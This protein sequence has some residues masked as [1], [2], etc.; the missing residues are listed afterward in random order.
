[1]R[2]KPN[3]T[4]PKSVINIKRAVKARDGY[5]CCKCGAG[6]AKTKRN[7][8]GLEVH[9]LVPGSKYTVGGCVTLCR[10]C[11]DKEPK[12]CHLAIAATL[13]VLAA[14]ISDIKL[15]EKLED[16]QGLPGKTSQMLVELLDFLSEATGRT[17]PST[18]LLH[19][20]IAR[21]HARLL[22]LGNR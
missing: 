18:L 9:R 7:K 1:M 15:P 12:T 19:V 8:G 21:E 4:E 14:L 2:T 10:P 13:K 6:E 5:R 11:H 3:S 22:P 16:C 20:L 17:V